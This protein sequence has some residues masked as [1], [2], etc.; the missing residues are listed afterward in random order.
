MGPQDW[1][2]RT[3]TSYDTV[4][5]A[6]ADFVRGRTAADSYD[7]ALLEL[8]VALVQAGG[9][10]PV[11]DMGCGPGEL[12]GTLRDL[13]VDARGLDLSP[14]MIALARRDHP[15]VP[16]EV[17]S[18]TEVEFPDASLGGIVSWYSLIHVPDD[19]A[20]RVLRRWARMLRPGGVVLLGFHVGVRSSHKLEGYGGHPMDLWVHRRTP[21]QLAE[22]LTGAGLTV[23]LQALRDHAADVPQAR[24]FARRPD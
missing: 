15:G 19:D 18:M 14:A 11:L 7:R 6:Y 1:L 20:V 13:G 4:A 5:A 17:G 24:V 21:E 10:G 3:R 2:A 12:T 8:F 16:F 23:D 9:G 22:W